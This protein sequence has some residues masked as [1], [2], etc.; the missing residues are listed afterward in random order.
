[1]LTAAEFVNG[2]Q[3]AQKNGARAIL[4]L[5]PEAGSLGCPLCASLGTL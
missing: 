5:G 1:V 3:L 4:M 2:Y